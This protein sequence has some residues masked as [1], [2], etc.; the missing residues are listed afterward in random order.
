LYAHGAQPE[1]AI[2]MLARIMARKTLSAEERKTY[3][4]IESL[5]SRRLSLGDQIIRRFEVF[6]HIAPYFIWFADNLKEKMR[7]L[8]LLRG[9]QTRTINAVKQGL[10]AGADISKVLFTVHTLQDC[11]E[12]AILLIARARQLGMPFN[13]NWVKEWLNSGA[14]FMTAVF[15]SDP[16][17]AHHLV[18]DLLYLQAAFPAAL[19]YR[20]D[21]LKDRTN[22]V[23]LIVENARRLG[24]TILEQSWLI[25]WRAQQ[26]ELIWKGISLDIDC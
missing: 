14:A 25:E 23:L 19:I 17:M 16:V 10:D 24:L 21:E 13:P 8:L 2:H 1:K 26:A 7:D 5:L 4:T 3:Q 9:I 15:H 22:T 18:K 20:L 11:P 12:I 6:S